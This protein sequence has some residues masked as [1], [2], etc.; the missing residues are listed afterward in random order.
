M[1]FIKK[2]HSNLIPQ[3]CEESN[4]MKLSLSE[5]VNKSNEG[6][7][8]VLRK[9]FQRKY[10]VTIFKLIGPFTDDKANSISEDDIRSTAYIRNFDLIKL[11]LKNFGEFVYF[12]EINFEKMDEQQGKEIVK[13]INEKTSE[14]LLMLRLLSCKGCVLDEL[15][16][17]FQ[18]V[19]STNFSSSYSQSLVVPTD[20]PKFNVIFP[21]LTC[22]SIE[23]TR[24]TDWKLIGDDIE[25]LDFLYIDLPKEDFEGLPNENYVENLVR[26][27][28]NI[29][30][31]SI[32]HSSLSLLKELNEKLPKLGSLELRFLSKDYKNYQGNSINFE[33]V[34][35]LTIHIDHNDDR[36]PDGIIFQQIQVLDLN[37]RPEFTD[38]WID[39][40]DTQIN[41]NI[42]RF[43]LYT[44]LLSSEHL[45]E[46][47]EKLTTLEY[48]V[49]SCG[50]QF[51]A[52]EIITFL[53]K[54]ETI[55]NAVFDIRMTKSEQYILKSK[56]KKA[57]KC[58]INPS[59]KRVY[60]TIERYSF[61]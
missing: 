37:I 23:Y 18:N 49:I 51:K 40:I 3:D 5:I 32:Q 43:E 7:L 8:C 11:F 22:L 60:M 2:N 41:Q 50:T 25:K 29:H 26:K 12:I 61:F 33:H 38:N 39:F 59:G 24:I 45:V 52:I 14:S 47:T 1:S 16:K 58:E 27:N 56:L 44:C 21:S 57:W 20:A 28:P 54:I 53:R 55:K 31:L 46:I 30:T 35:F 19:V 13:C 42:S 6:C 15:K 10:N 4:I 17:P 9:V 48:S 36:I 34:K